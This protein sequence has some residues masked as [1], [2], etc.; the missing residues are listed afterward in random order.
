MKLDEWERY[1][2]MSLMN[3]KILRLQDFEQSEGGSIEPDAMRAKYPQHMAL[4]QKLID[5][6]PET[7][8][9]QAHVSIW[10]NHERSQY[11]SNW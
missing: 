1:H 8:G 7:S 2:L 3:K 4:M 5:W 10:R 11:R 6:K 9:S